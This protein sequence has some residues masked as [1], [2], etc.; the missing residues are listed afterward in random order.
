MNYEFTVRNEKEPLTKRAEKCVREGEEQE[1]VGEN[2][3]DDAG[4][5][6]VFGHDAISCPRYYSFRRDKANLA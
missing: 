2:T 6:P 1:A 3:K 5:Y 4:G